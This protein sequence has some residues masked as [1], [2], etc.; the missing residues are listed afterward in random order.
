M[1]LC[2]L[3]WMYLYFDRISLRISLPQSHLEFLMDGGFDR[4]SCTFNMTR[5]ISLRD[6]LFFFNLTDYISQYQVVLFSLVYSL[7]L[8][9]SKMKKIKSKNFNP[10]CWYSQFWWI[11]Y[12]GMIKLKLF[13]IFP[14]VPN[15]RAP[16][17]CYIFFPLPVL[18][19]ISEIRYLYLFRCIPFRYK[20]SVENQKVL[21]VLMIS[22]QSGPGLLFPKVLFIFFFIIYFL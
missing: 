14:S 6:T 18:W 11:I 1:W 8:V 22:S 5:S 17:P 16:V 4:I 7:V 2:M 21:E 9:N 3:H 19:K 15:L 12:P 10:F 13:I 20:N